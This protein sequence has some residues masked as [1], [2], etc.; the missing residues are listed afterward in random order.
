MICERQDDPLT[1]IPRPPCARL[2]K[3]M[4]PSLLTTITRTLGPWNLRRHSAPSNPSR[5]YAVSPD[6][7]ADVHSPPMTPRAR[8]VP[9]DRKGKTKGQRAKVRRL[10]RE[11][12]ATHQ[13]GMVSLRKGDYA[14]LDAAIAK[15]RGILKEQAELI[16]ASRRAF[17]DRTTPKRKAAKKR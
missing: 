15:E 8:G 2:F 10:K 13:S 12:D 7:V 11:F 6:T 9:D 16:A 5:I 14:A 3:T 17:K 4:K 1:W